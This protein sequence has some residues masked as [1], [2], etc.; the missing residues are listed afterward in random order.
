M[1]STT[2]CPRA[3]LPARALSAHALSARARLCTRLPART[4]GLPAPAQRLRLRC[5]AGEDAPEDAAPAPAPVSGEEG[6]D[7]GGTPRKRRT[8]K[9]DSTDPVATFLTRRFGVAGGLAW[10][11]V[12]TF[13]VVSEQLKTRQ[14]VAREESGT[15]AVDAM[16][17]A[18][19]SG[20]RYTDLVRGGGETAPQRGYLLA[21][22]VRVV[23]GEDP[24]GP[25][26]FDTEDTGRPLAFFFGCGGRDLQRPAPSM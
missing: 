15:Q 24:A 25:V 13:G 5:S 22:A 3:A 7:A 23:L 12:L 16:E 8:R 2:L 4:G 14:E 18:T 26:L 19:A 11:G 9:A 6:E 10:L 20:L 17:V 21:A 1:K